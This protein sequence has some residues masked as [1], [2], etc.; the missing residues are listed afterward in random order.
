MERLF[1]S[2]GFK[3]YAK[4]AASAC[5]STCHQ[6]YDASL[7]SWRHRGEGKNE[8][9]QGALCSSHAHHALG[10]SVCTIYIRN[11]WTN[12][13]IASLIKDVL[14]PPIILGP[15]SLK[16]TYSITKY[17]MKHRTSWV[18]LA[19]PDYKQVTPD[20]KETTRYHLWNWQALWPWHSQCAQQMSRGYH[21]SSIKK[22]TNK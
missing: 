2:W 18:L 17:W 13:N 4:G 19:V 8:L 22:N 20:I 21:F 10:S 12:L 6:P 7:I 11:M 9:L 3:L 16:L 5:K 1:H 15:F 14:C